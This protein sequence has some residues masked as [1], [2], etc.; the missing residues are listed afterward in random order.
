MFVYVYR[1]RL[2][3]L[4]EQDDSPS[5]TAA[6]NTDA[7]DKRDIQYVVDAGARDDIRLE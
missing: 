3:R 2:H 1:D 5:A 7:S 4:A 6:S